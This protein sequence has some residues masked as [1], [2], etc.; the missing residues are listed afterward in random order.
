MKVLIYLLLAIL[1]IINFSRCKSG[2]EII[3]FKPYKP[4]DY[5]TKE[6]KVCEVKERLYKI[7]D[8]IMIQNPVCRNL[9]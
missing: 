6:I 5:I 1:V 7:L 3:R 8:S 4:K 2:E 9:K